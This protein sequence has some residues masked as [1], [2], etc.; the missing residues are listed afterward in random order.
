MG[1]MSRTIQA[2]TLARDGQRS[3]VGERLIG[4]RDEN[5]CRKGNTM[6]I[7]I[8]IDKVE[9]LKAGKDKY[10]PVVVDVP[11]ES[12]TPEQRA[13][14]AEQTWSRGDQPIADFYLDCG[15][16]L[17][18]SKGIAEATHDTVRMILDRLIAIRR[19]KEIKKAAEEV[20]AKEKLVKETEE[21]L[22]KFAKNP[23]E[24]A[25]E[26]RWNNPEPISLLQKN[27][28]ELAE[29]AQWAKE[30]C[31]KIREELNQEKARN[32][33]LEKDRAA[34]AKAQKKANE[35]ALREWA[36]T[37][38]SDLLKA[39]I[40]DNFE[41]IGLAER[42]FALSIVSELGS[43]L[44]IPDHEENEELE[45]TTPTLPEI[46]RLREVRK[47]L[48]GKPARCELIWATYNDE[49]KRAEIH[50]VVTTPTGRIVDF[51]YPATK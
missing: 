11:A 16:G 2:S 10:G 12:L 23:R 47:L 5:S 50:V 43:E 45:R 37:N 27:I 48:E 34:L 39:R 3:H 4:S 51:Y 41:W 29:V 49:I 20:E 25:I 19:E 15:D 18:E 46:Q 42:E 30:E 22:K 33:Q 8:S 14:L 38:G 17:K 28:P 13:E 9:A 24:A 35:N 31:E 7:R 36:E 6:K 44:D 1:A 26:I 21:F 40:A 32:Q